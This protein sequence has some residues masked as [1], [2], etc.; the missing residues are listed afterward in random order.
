MTDL[1]FLSATEMASGIRRGE[2]SPLE[3]LEAHFA[4]IDRLNPQ[5]NA[6]ISM[7]REEALDLARRASSTLRHENRGK[8]NQGRKSKHRPK[9]NRGDD[10]L[11]P[12]YG[13]PITIKSSINVAGLRCE[14]G[15]RLRSGHIPVADAALVANLKAAGAII[16]GTTSTPELLMA[17]ETENLLYGR[18]NNPWD[19][20]RSPGG[21][22]GGEAASIGAGCSAGGIGSDGG[23][24]IR[25]PAH[26]CGICGLKPTP[27]RV[28]ATGH[29]PPA[30]GPFSLTGVVGPMARTVRDLSLLFEVIAQPDDADVFSTPLPVRWPSEA[31]VLRARVGYFEDYGI[32]PATPETRAAVR[33]AA[34]ALSEQGFEV[35]E[36]RP[37]GL[38]R[39]RELWEIFFV[40]TGGLFVSRMVAGHESEIS[41][42]LKE[43]LGYVS[44]RPP[45]TRDMLLQAWI[46]RDQLRC[47]L[48]EQMRKFP[49]L[50]CPVCAVPAFEHSE[51]SWRRS[52]KIDG[53]TVS[54]SDAMRYMQW[55]NLTGNP[56][57]VVPV[58]KSPEG[59]PIGVQIVGRPHEEE[60][61]LLVAEKLE[62][63][64]GGYQIPPL[65]AK[66]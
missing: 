23:G 59:L 47:H 65:A 12:L 17:Y 41:P 18:T 66:S 56:A 15:T 5:L 9:S 53:H 25:E 6:I 8:S 45:L 61:V 44:E 49:I 60:L 28:P 10:A 19:L 64:V 51:H 3:L 54:Y 7:N 33:K 36:F 30:G 16:L 29:Y 37:E 14:A 39:A 48:L 26:F 20:A 55:F 42:G 52:W 11:G 34:R 58:G 21:S 1:V 40:V 32:S 57:V 35:A 50:L 13:V 4:Q 46:G 43:F 22:S 27:G 38:E 31:D 24:S 2:F 63:T 62:Q